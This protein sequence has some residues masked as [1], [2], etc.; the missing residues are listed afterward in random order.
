M[1]SSDATIK[2][3]SL[4]SKYGIPLKMLYFFVNFWYF[5]F[6]NYRGNFADKYFSISKSSF[7]SCFGVI[8][9]LCFFTNSFIATLNDKFENPKLLIFILLGVSTLAFELF[10]FISKD[11][12]V[13]FW[14]ILAVYSI[15]STGMPALL[16]RFTIGYLS[17]RPDLSYGTQ[18]LF[19]T[20]GYLAVNLTVEGYIRPAGEFDFN[21]LKYFLPITAIPAFLIVF[22]VVKSYKLRAENKTTAK[23]LKIEQIEDNQQVDQCIDGSQGINQEKIGE[24][25]D[26]SSDRK[27]KVVEIKAKE[28]SKSKTSLALGWVELLKNSEYLFFIFIIFLNGLTRAS[29]TIYL[30]VYLDTILKPPQAELAT[31]LIEKLKLSVF[32]KPFGTIATS[33]VII[34]IVI[35]FSSKAIISTMGLYWPLLIAQIVQVGRFAGY[36][37]LTYYCKGLDDD[38][39]GYKMLLLIVAFLELCKGINFG[40]THSSAVY[41]A[42]ELCQSHLKAT[43]Q[44]VYTG[45]F[46]G[47]S[48]FF[49]GLFFGYLFSKSEGNKGKGDIT[50]FRTFFMANIIISCFSCGL[51]LLKYGFFDGILWK[52][53]EVQSNEE[54]KSQL[55]GN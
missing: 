15:F 24:N 8:L 22:F 47:L 25:T 55:K 9:L 27:E 3:Q 40:L 37:T 34:E 44:M 48:T 18:R 11:N 32:S 31:N 28:N 5:T 43:S 23:E 17:T 19:G 51:F 53:R 4:F 1:S 49:A 6:Y 50:E 2:K 12:K 29:M 45:A 41:I 10:Y 30:T 16:D 21:P 35:M 54:K 7:G 36:V 26:E 46:Q 52:R 14:A 38:I 33:A 39:L 13:M 20:L 42:N